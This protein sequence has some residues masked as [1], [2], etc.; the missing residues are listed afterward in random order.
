MELHNKLMS[1]SPEFT[2]YTIVENN[3]TKYK[4]IGSFYKSNHELLLRFYYVPF[5]S[6]DVEKSIWFWGDNILSLNKNLA[7]EIKELRKELHKELNN[8]FS[9]NNFS[10]ISTNDLN[11]NCFMIE[12][13][14]NKNISKIIGSRQNILNFILIDKILLN[15]L[16]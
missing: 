8:D 14:F 1:Y 3:I 7:A 10:V 11:N 5:G 2:T 4:Y 15:N 9:K 6:Y 13:L 12:K 16:D